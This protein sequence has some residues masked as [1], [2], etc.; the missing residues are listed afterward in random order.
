MAAPDRVLAGVFATMTR[1]G[2][3]AVAEMD[4]FPRF[5]PDNLGLGAEGLEARCR[6]ALAAGLTDEMPILG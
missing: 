1:G 2:L 6:A 3:M 5:L 4:S